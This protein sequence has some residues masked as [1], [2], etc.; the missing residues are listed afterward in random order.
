MNTMNESEIVIDGNRLSIAEVG[1]VAFEGRSVS[2]SSEATERMAQSRKV[3]EEI[4]KSER[5]VYGVNTGFGKLSEIRI[6]SGQLNELQMNLLRS[7]AAGVGEPFAIPVTRAIM[8]LRANV[9]AKGF[10][11]IR[12]KVVQLLLE[13]LNKKIHPLIPSKGSVGASGDLA[14]LAHLALVLIGEGSAVC[15]S[16]ILPGKLALSEKGLS[17]VMLEAKEGLALI[18]GTQV[19]TAI[20]ALSCLQ[21]RRMCK[22]ADLA[23]AMSVDVLRGTDTAFDPRI[24]ESRPYPGA[25]RVA[26]NLRDLIRGS[27]IRESHRDSPHKVQDH[28]SLRC[29]PQVHGAVRDALAVGENWITLELNAA[30]DNPLVFSADR[31]LLS[32]GNF[33]GAPVSMCLD[34]LAIAVAQLANV[35]E[36]RTALLV[37]SSQSDLPPFLTRDSGLNSGFMIAQVTSAALVSEN[38]ILA[39]PASVDSIPTSANKEDHVSMGVTAALKLQQMIQNCQHVLTIELLCASQAL[40]LLRPLESSIA[41]KKAHESVRTRV[42]VMEKDRV[43]AEDIASLLQLINSP[44]F[45]Q[46]VEKILQHEL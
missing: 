21:L 17:P 8:L 38:K 25:I 4:L 23:G 16:Q 12:S 14:P 36:R 2:L 10:S 33:H 26:A 40:D 1:A 22:L 28:Y 37:D 45:L 9:L 41:L 39:H 19:M 27:G 11:G 18:N 29:M 13:M 43:I 20:G 35:S 34:F 32:G 6:P 30:T 3:I 7:H 5:V 24:V 31:Q 46:D 15:E 42:P 44:A